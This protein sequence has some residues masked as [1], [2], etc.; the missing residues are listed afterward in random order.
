VAL[1]AG[2]VA[3]P[4]LTGPVV[5][6]AGM[7]APGE[8]ARLESLARAARS[9]EG[10]RGIQLQFLLVPSLEGDPIEDFS[11]RVAERWKL[12]T[13]G[14][15]NGLL[16]V[17]ARDDR[18]IRIEVGGGLEG[19]LTDAQ[20]GRIIRSVIVPAFRAGRAGEGLEM[21][22]HQAL[23]ALGAP[24]AGAPA[25]PRSRRGGRG[26]PIGWVIALFCL[27]F[28][29]RS[30]MGFS[31]LGGRRR[32]RSGLGG[33]SGGGWRGGGGFGGGGWGGGGGGFSGGGASGRW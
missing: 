9:T 7:L 12:G 32:W 23:A 3:V 13:K 30:L 18:A 2:E 28:V 27:S 21:A 6:L 22:A 5:D 15:D 25:P 16:F 26:L 19:G 33:W 8:E 29:A 17:V 4:E 20:A 10:G 24:Q 14:S 31:P 1:A 11:M